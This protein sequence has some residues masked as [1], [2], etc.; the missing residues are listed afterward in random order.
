MA[1]VV[2]SLVLD[3][4]E[5]DA[6]LRP[7]GDVLVERAGPRSTSG[8]D[9]RIDA[10]FEVEHGPLRSYDRSV[11]ATPRADGAFDVTERTRFQMAIPLWG[12]L[13]VPLYRREIRRTTA[14]DQP[15]QPFWAPPDPVDARAA[16]VLGLLCTVALVAGY[17]GT[18]VTQ[19]ITYA[20]DSFGTSDA[21]QG[22]TLA[23][24]RV[25]VLL[26]LVL[27][28]LADRQGRR[29]LVIASGIGSCLTCALGA[30][31]PNMIVLAGTQVISRGLSMTVVMLIT[32]MAAEEM[33]AGSRA[34]AISVMTMTGAL[35]AGMC[36]WALP[37]TDIGSDGWRLLY[38]IPLLG[39]PVMSRVARHLPESQRFTVPH[40]EVGLLRD[41]RRRLV[42]L[43]T[44]FFL[45]SSFAAPASQLMNDFLKDERGFSPSHIALFTM[46]T[47]TP[48]GIGLVI[49]GRMADV[50]GKRLIV[51]IGVAGGALL[52]LFSFMSFGWPMW[53]WNLVGTILAAGATPALGMYGPE[54][55]PTGS[56]GK[57]NGIIQ[58]VSVAGSALGLV[59][60]GRMLD[61][62]GLASA[63][64][65]LLI[66]PLIVG[67]MVLF[68]FPETARRELEDLNP[69]DQP[70]RDEAEVIAGS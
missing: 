35:G 33:P 43:G 25:G 54:L 7:R 59:I 29:R 64:R 66:G 4:S 42:L 32:V 16:R 10:H 48:G 52:T 50:R 49:G 62:G 26:S 27:V 40:R 36:L 63:M 20:T 47:T 68:W 28:A 13:F 46:L 31:A 44:A 56:R 8:P 18:V 61:H 70:F 55:F 51:S 23:A 34:Y 69:E 41:H 12:V 45:I 5:L 58:T 21:A 1:T 14:R 38:V 37:L 15:R 3:R 2:N 60:A 53:I 17:L 9:G 11:E 65:P 39:I 19:T 57:A 22:N 6:L 30:A 24:V 67:V